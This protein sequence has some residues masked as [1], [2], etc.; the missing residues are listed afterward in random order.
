MNEPVF[1]R[2]QQAVVCLFSRHWEK[3]PLFRN[4]QPCRIDTHFPDFTMEDQ[5]SGSEEAIEF[6]YA[7][8]D[9]NRIRD[10]RKPKDEGIGVLY[11]VYWDEDANRD[12]SISC[13]YAAPG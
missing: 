2:Q 13:I 10:L 3:I 4:K 7:L 11:I 5:D 1:S 8:S 6:E 9:F 12:E